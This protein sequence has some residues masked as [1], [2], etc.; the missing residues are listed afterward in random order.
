[1]VLRIILPI[2]ALMLAPTV[3]SAQQ[4]RVWVDTDLKSGKLMGD[5]DDALAL[6]LLLRDTSVH[7]EGI[8]VVHGVRHARKV[9]A[10][11]LRWYAP[12]RNIPVHVGA[13]SQKELGQRTDAANAIIRALEKGPMQVLALG[14]ATNIAT[15]LQ[16][17]PDLRDRIQTVSFC[18]G[19]R[20]GMRFAP[21]GG[22]VNFSDYN[23]EHDSVAGRILLQSGVPL[24]MAGYDCSDGFYLHSA[25][26]RALKGSPDP[27]DRWMHRK[28]RRWEWVWRNIFGVKDG[29]IPFD[30]STVGAL[31]YPEDFC[32][33]KGL[34]ATVAQG[35]NDARSIVKTDRKAMLLVGQEG[36]S[37]R[38]DYCYHTHGAFKQRLLKALL[39]E[40]GPR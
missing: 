14:P 33:R 39:Q 1:M 12:E 25:D 28:L 35:D 26:Y 38:V 10:R 36:G 30:C 16:Q 19:R 32:I 24:L 15:V 9:T 21:F 8:S 4:H 37:S 27:G 31:L 34:E 29:F 13:D 20:P 5:M 40:V 6:V 7:I 3:V 11:L 18:A 2:L 17:R 23:F 22:K